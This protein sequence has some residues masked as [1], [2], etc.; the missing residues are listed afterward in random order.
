MP[1][2]VSQKVSRLQTLSLSFVHKRPSPDMRLNV[3]LVQVNNGETA[4]SKMLVV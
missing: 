1:S 3:A 4:K 2:Q